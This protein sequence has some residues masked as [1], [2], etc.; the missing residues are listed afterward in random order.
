MNWLGDHETTWQPGLAIG[1]YSRVV[2]TSNDRM[3]AVD[4][5]GDPLLLDLDDAAITDHELVL[6]GT[7]NDVNY[8]GVRGGKN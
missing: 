2:V 7:L 4:A 1:R 8:Y 6:A 5:N 3:I